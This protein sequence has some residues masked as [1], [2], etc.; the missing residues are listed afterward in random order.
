[1]LENRFLQSF[2]T[3]AVSAVLVGGTLLLLTSAAPW[4]PPQQI[5]SEPS[6]PDSA[7]PSM[8][9]ETSIDGQLP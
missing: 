7:R 4:S 8:Q 6:T 1:M 3:V 9:E 2:C 5:D